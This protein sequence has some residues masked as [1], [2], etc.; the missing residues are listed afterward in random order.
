MAQVSRVTYSPCVAAMLLALLAGAAAAAAPGPG[1]A[2]VPVRRGQVTTVVVTDDV[3]A[4]VEL[5]VPSRAY[6]RAAAADGEQ[7]WTDADG[8]YGE[9]A[10]EWRAIA[11][12]QPSPA[13]EL[14]ILKAE[15]ERQRSQQ[16]AMRARAT[17][18]R[19]P[20]PRPRRAEA[21][22]EA[23][24]LRAKLMAVRAA[25]G[26]VP[27]ALYARAR[28]RLQDALRADDPATPEGPD[29]RTGD[30]EAYLWLCTVRAAGGDP[31]GAR[32]ARAHVTQAQRDQ[33]ANTVP[34]AAC[35]AALGE[36][37]AALSILEMVALNPG[38]SSDRF[39]LRDLYILNDWD[40]LRGDPRFESLFPR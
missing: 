21:L 25:S 33:P 9:A 1:T 31:E 17:A 26:W 11:R 32:I 12:I 29:A 36:T 22:E 4:P 16:L 14:A 13:L 37:R 5:A 24:L 23:R 10:N 27:P 2:S 39:A 38:P 34:L 35:A 18:S 8:L 20:G 30:G 28:D 15:R 19:V 7:R 3:G 40:R 6:L